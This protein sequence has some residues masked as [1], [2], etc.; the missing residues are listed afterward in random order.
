MKIK[1][2]F[3][4]RQVVDTWVVL[5]LADKTVD[6]NGM[7]T[8][9]ES[10]V[11]LWNTLEQGADEETLVQALRNEYDVSAE[12]ARADVREFLAKLK[13]VGCIDEEERL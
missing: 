2:T 8:L 7:I 5:P 10:G 1:D 3:V 4:L 9:N 13:S 11:L 12:D 6:F